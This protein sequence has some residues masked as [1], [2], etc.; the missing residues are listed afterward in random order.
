MFYARTSYPNTNTGGQA[1]PETGLRNLNLSA[2]T[3]CVT[4]ADR[5]RA[6]IEARGLGVQT[7]EVLA[8]TGRGS[9]HNLLSGRKKAPTVETL[10][11]VAK[12][13]HVSFAWLATGEGE[14]ELAQELVDDPYPGRADLRRTAYW[15]TLP[16]DLQEDILD[17]TAADPGMSLEGWVTLVQHLRKVREL[18]VPP[19][20]PAPKHAPEPRRARN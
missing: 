14:M 10:E 2:I 20:T 12:A 16:Q 1:C 8:D 13:L 3:A 7:V 19:S 15:R 5:I 18:T 4:A 9:L 17:A 6:A 11:K